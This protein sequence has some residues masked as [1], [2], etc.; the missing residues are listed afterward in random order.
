[1]RSKLPW[2]PMA[3]AVCVLLGAG[4]SSSDDSDSTATNASETTAAEGQEGEAASVES[5]AEEVGGAVLT[6]AG[7]DDASPRDSKYVDQAAGAFSDGGVDVAYDSA[8]LESDGQ[9]EIKNVD[10]D[11][12]CLTLPE[13]IDGTSSVKSG[14]CT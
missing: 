2:A 7:E 5:I 13:T 6:L 4:C 9:V 14:S 3:I 10:G 12:A 11:T 8:T 1:M